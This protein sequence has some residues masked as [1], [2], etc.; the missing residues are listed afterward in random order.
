MKKEKE[1]EMISD[2]SYCTKMYYTHRKHSKMDDVILELLKFIHD[3]QEEWLED[4]PP[5]LDKQ[6]NDALNPETIIHCHDRSNPNTI[7]TFFNLD[8][9][10]RFVAVRRFSD[11]KY[12]YGD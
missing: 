2:L 6:I 12:G 10:K 7:R 1:A 8:P 3:I 5:S 9:S 11:K 4:S